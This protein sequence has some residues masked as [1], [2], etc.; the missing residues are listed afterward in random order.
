MV[1]PMGDSYLDHNNDP[2]ITIGSN[3]SGFRIK[4]IGEVVVN[5]TSWY[6]CKNFNKE[7]RNCDDYENRPNMCKDHPHA[8][9]GCNYKACTLVCKS[10]GEM[11]EEAINAIG[12]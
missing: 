11:V 7:T 2:M 1:I 3:R 12:K 8:F 4:Q 10:R 9:E 5:E 6:T